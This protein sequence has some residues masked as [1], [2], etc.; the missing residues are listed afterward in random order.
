MFF[1]FTQL[2]FIIY[3]K[4]VFEEWKPV[5][6]SEIAVGLG[7]VF[8]GSDLGIEKKETGTILALLLSDLFLE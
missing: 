2:L 4:Q 3:N 7:S 1:L 6:W 5:G 8:I